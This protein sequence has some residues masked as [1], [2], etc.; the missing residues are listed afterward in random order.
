MEQSGAK[1]RASWLL[2]CEAA[3]LLLLT[4]PQFPASLCHAKPERKTKISMLEVGP[5]FS[6]HKGEAMKKIITCT[7]LVVLAA[8]TPVSAQAVITERNISADA[9]FR[10]AQASIAACKKTGYDISVVVVDRNGIVRLAVRADTASPHNF[11][12]ARRKA[13]TAR[14]F[15]RTSAS[16]AKRMA[17]EPELSGQKNLADVI[18]LGGGVPIEAGKETIGAVGVSGSPGQDKDEACAAA[19]IAAIASELK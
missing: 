15:R 14:T 10:I 16:W 8:T 5:G 6:A 13:Y 1:F 3:R 19:G 17:D 7:T 12:L 11:E 4:G 2:A 9:A 18:P